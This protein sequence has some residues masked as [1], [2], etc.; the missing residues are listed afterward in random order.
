MA[1]GADRGAP[2]MDIFESS[3]PAA[4]VVKNK[5]VDVSRAKLSQLPSSQELSVSDIDTQIHK[6]L[7]LGADLNPWA[8]PAPLQ[9]GVAST[10]VSMFEPVSAAYVI[11]SFDRANGLAH[12]LGGARSRPRDAHPLE[13]VARQ[14]ASHASSGMVWARRERE[15]S[16]LRRSGEW[17]PPLDLGPPVRGKRRGR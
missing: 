4:P 16:G 6:V 5:D 8:S 17:I 1:G 9:E 12:G 3:D 13:D 2:P 10:R 7:D 14:E 15:R 11:L